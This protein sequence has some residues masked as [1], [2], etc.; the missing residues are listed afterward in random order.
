[1]LIDKNLS[2][3]GSQE[4]QGFKLG[5]TGKTQN[6]SQLC[7]AAGYLSM[8][9]SINPKWEDTGGKSTMMRKSNYIKTVIQIVQEIL[10][11]TSDSINTYS[12]I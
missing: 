1:M 11:Y 9:R 12:F 6:S 7:M 4:K 2:V 5:V 10:E 3:S 8:L